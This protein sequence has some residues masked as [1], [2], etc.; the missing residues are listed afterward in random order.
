MDWSTI[1]TALASSFGLSIT[2]AYWLVRSLIQNRLAQAL[3]ERKGEITEQL[4]LQ[5]AAAAQDLE[6]LRDGLQLQQSK[7]KSAID[8]EIRKEIEVQLGEIGAQRQYEYEAKRRLYLSIG[9]L[10]FQLLL[11]C[12]DLVGRIKSIGTTENYR[13][14][15]DEYYGRSTIYRLL[16]PIALASLI[17]EQM[18]IND[19]SVDREAIDCLR[20]RRAVTRIFSGD[21][22]SDGHPN[23]DWSQQKEHVFADSLASAVQS[24]IERV[25]VNQSRILRFDEFKEKI[26]R[27]GWVAASPIDK[28]FE[29][30]TIDRK[31]ILWL[32]LV[33]YAQIC[34]SFV[35]RQ[36]Q[37][38]G[39][40]EEYFDTQELLLRSRDIFV[41]TEFSGLKEKIKKLE[42]LPL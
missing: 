13:I 31:P 19:F 39:F 12:R 18:A 26:E 35:T 32:R 30:F 15:L 33:A 42:T 4:E 20:F 40:A 29:Q 17:E 28:I 2:G 41:K 3:E 21:E 36:G 9:P 7:A 24:I 11:A 8:A 25:D 23:V 1:F 37:A 22:L 34:N 10:R 38:R 5:K 16:K 27:D 6:R 14:Q